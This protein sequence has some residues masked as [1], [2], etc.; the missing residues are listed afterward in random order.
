M[1]MDDL[2]VRADA[3]PDVQE[4]PK[5]KPDAQ[6]QPKSKEK[7]APE[8]DSKK[9]P[10]STKPKTPEP[11]VQGQPNARKKKDSAQGQLK[12][13]E[14]KASVKSEIPVAQ[15]SNAAPPKEAPPAKVVD[16]DG[17]V[18]VYPRSAE[19]E[20][21]ES[22]NP[23]PSET[24]L[25]DNEEDAGMSE[26]CNATQE[27]ALTANISIEIR[28]STVEKT[29]GIPSRPPPSVCAVLLGRAM[30]AAKLSKES[31]PLTKAIAE[32]GTS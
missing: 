5:S 13:S 24:Q 29:A 11:E 26:E 27:H 30:S 4:L 25:G 32:A 14:K 16:G 17:D 12:S 9:Q 28:E 31:T 15:T 10:K 1:T 2:L 21:Q 22:T 8:L 20:V 19:L 7:K 3:E 18:S 23:P 6:A